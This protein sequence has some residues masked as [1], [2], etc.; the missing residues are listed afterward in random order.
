MA[1]RKSI[2]ACL[3]YLPDLAPTYIT[4]LGSLEAEAFC[5]KHHMSRIP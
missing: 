5:N 3:V 4:W 2:H 1:H